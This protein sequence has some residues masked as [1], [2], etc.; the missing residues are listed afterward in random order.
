MRV[1]LFTATLLLLLATAVG[2][3]RQQ[4]MD[5]AL[6]YADVNPRDGKIT[7]QEMETA[8]RYLQL[9]R[10]IDWLPRWAKDL[11]KTNEQ[12]MA[13]CDFD[14]DGAISRQD[15]VLSNRTCLGNQDTLD[16][17]KKYFCDKAAEA[18]NHRH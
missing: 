4:A 15:M 14:H 13:D 5:C 8:R 10:L 18:E 16:K 2:F 6:R 17:F 1:H 12:V 3:T 11:V 9:P 7:L